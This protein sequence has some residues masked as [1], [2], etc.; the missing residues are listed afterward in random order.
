MTTS[1]RGRSEWFYGDHPPAC[2]C[3]DCTQ[4]RMNWIEQEGNDLPPM[5]NQPSQPEKPG[6][7]R[8]RWGR[9]VIAILLLVLGIVGVAVWLFAFGGINSF[10]GPAA[11]APP[12]TGGVQP[13]SDAQ[14]QA[15][16]ADELTR[17]APTLTP[18]QPPTYPPGEVRLTLP[19]PTAAATLLPPTPTNGISVIPIWSVPTTTATSMRQ[20]QPTATPTITPRP[21]PTATS[22][23]HQAEATAIT[24]N[25]TNDWD[26]AWLPDGRR[27]AFNSD[28]NGDRDIY[29]MNADGSDVVQ[30]T[31]NPGGDGDPAWSPDGRWIAFISQRDGDWDWDNWDWE[32]DIYVMNADGSGVIQL[33]DNPGGDGDPAWSP[34]GRWIA[35]TSG[36]NIYVMNI[37]G[38]GCDP[39]Y[40]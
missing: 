40:Q 13:P 32:W 12:S 34:D 21:R 27:I 3:S 18:E 11:N 33:T 10:D 31:D 28:R 17:A 2:T 6:S 22:K 37:D 7:G 30:L 35:F 39:T 23:S 25:S 9:W 29:V 38:S 24:H 16:I 4:R 14:L 19:K 1:S 8:G 20:R 15:M 26:P 5:Q 36:G